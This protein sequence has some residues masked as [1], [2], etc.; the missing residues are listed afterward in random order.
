MRM[1]NTGGMR[2]ERMLGECIDCRI[3]ES[4][5]LTEM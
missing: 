4:M 1:W 3:R 5:G 2:S